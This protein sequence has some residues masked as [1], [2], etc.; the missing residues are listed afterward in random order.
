MVV[1]HAAKVVAFGVLGFAF[2]EWIPMLVAMLVAGQVGTQVGA[3]ILRSLPE[4]GFEIAF[5]LILSGLALN[6]R[7]SAIMA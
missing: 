7:R 6:L 2:A 3:R 4:R 5:R 1:Q